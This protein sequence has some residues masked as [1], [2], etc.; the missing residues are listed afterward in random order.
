MN[1]DELRSQLIALG[2]VP[3]QNVARAIERFAIR[4]QDDEDRARTRLF[5]A[6]TMEDVMRHGLDTARMQAARAVCEAIAG[7]I[8]DAIANRQEES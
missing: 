5:A 6:E 2:D 1:A 3:L 7:G 8:F 4:F